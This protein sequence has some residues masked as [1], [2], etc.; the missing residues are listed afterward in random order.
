MAERRQ[1][2]RADVVDRDV[3]P[4]V[5]QRTDLAGGHER[6]RAARRPAVADV[7][8]DELGRA[9]LVR[10]GRREHAHRVG[11]DVRRDRDGPGEPLHLDDLGRRADL[12]GRSRVGAGRPLDDRDEV[13]LGRERDHDLEQEPVELRLGEGIG[14]LHLERVLRREHEERRIERV[15]LPGDRDLVLLHRLEQAG[16]GL[17]RRPVDLV[18]EDEVGEDRARLEAEDPAATLLDE[19]V[20]AGDVGRHEVRRELDP[21]ERA[22]D[23]VGDRPDEHRLAEA[24]DA[25]EQRVAVGQQAGQRV[26]DELAL[27]DDDPADFALDRLALARRTRRGRCG[28][29]ERPS[30]VGVAS[31]GSSGDG[32]RDRWRPAAVSSTGRAS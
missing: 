2:D 3:E 28:R 11:R 26:P 29:P 24:R 7:L 31:M 9:R 30:T 23:D 5:E 17:R 16:L 21:V 1:G 25:L 8:A 10:V 22:V 12:G 13:L 20:R 18:G 6:L 15:A 27:A 14:A 19:D 4:P 32:G